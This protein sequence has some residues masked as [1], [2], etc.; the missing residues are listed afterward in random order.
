[1]V[2][3]A[4]EVRRQTVLVPYYRVNPDPPT[5]Q[6][7]M[8]PVYVDPAPRLPA[9]SEPEPEPQSSEAD[10]FFD[11]LGAIDLPPLLDTSAEV[12]KPS[13]KDLCEKAERH[14][15]FAESLQK[16]VAELLDDATPGPPPPTR[17]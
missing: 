5:R 17:H 2:R 4:V 3:L 10:T 13:V 1:M 9:P 12:Q 11:M 8:K 6:T 16:L 7:V 15:K 14:Q